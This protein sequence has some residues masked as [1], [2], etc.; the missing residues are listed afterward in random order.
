MP[1]LA[2]VLRELK[3]E[4][5]LLYLDQVKMAFGDKPEIYNK[6]LDIMKNFKAQEIDTPGV[7]QQVSRLFCGNNKLILGFNTFLPDGYKIELPLEGGDA[8]MTVTT[9]SGVLA[10][11]V[12]G[13]VFPRHTSELQNRHVGVGG[14]NL[15]VSDAIV[16][17]DAVSGAPLEFDHAITYV[18]TI[19][20]RFAHE[21]EIYK[22]FLE[23]LH[24]YQKEQRSIK[25]VLEQV[26]Q[27]FA[28]H[29]DLLRE[30]T[31]F[32]PD[33]VQEQAKERLSR[34]AR[35]SELRRSRKE[36]ADYGSQYHSGIDRNSGAG[37]SKSA[38][39]GRSR[40]SS[41]SIKGMSR[42][43]IDST[44]SCRHTTPNT[45][46]VP[47]YSRDDSGKQMTCV[48]VDSSDRTFDG[49]GATKFMIEHHFFERIKESFALKAEAIAGV[50]QNGW[51]RFLK[52]IDLYSQGL[53]RRSDVVPLLAKL[54][55]SCGLSIE[56]LD[57]FDKMMHDKCGN[58][59]QRSGNEKA[60]AH[61]CI[62]SKGFGEVGMGGHLGTSTALHD[63]DFSSCKHGTPSYRAL[64]ASMLRQRSGKQMCLI[65]DVWVSQP[66]GSEGPQSFPHIWK[67]KH[68]EE[69][70]LCEDEHYELDMIL[71]ANAAAVTVLGSLMSRV[72]Q[73]QGN[74][75]ATACSMRINMT[76]DVSTLSSSHL[77][78]LL[79]LYGRHGV[80]LIELLY[81]HPQT[82]IP[83]IVKRLK[84]KGSEW[85]TVRGIFVEERKKQLARISSCAMDHRAYNFCQDD[86][87]KM[88]PRYLVQDIFE[89]NHSQMQVSRLR[90]MSGTRRSAMM[91]E[92]AGML[93][94]TTTEN[95][96]QPKMF[97]K[98]G[99][100]CIH[101]R[102]FHLIYNA[103]ERSSM[104]QHNKLSVAKFWQHFFAHFLRLPKDV[105]IV[106]P[107]ESHI[108][109]YAKDV[110]NSAQSNT[111][112]VD[113]S[114]SGLSSPDPLIICTPEIY[115]FFRLYHLL[116]QR[117]EF[118][119]RAC[120]TRI[121]A[122]LSIA[123]RFIGGNLEADH[124]KEGCRILFGS[125]SFVL[126]TIDKLTVLIL[127]QLQHLVNDVLS[128]KI[129][130]L[131]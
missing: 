3:V 90:E 113:E 4:D 20:K 25:D 123:H 94:D 48:P 53:L 33:A 120:P 18:T 91:Q 112:S 84:Q 101:S 106:T 122:L 41:T 71:N 109:T 73:Q 115:T 43:S 86:R 50:A 13:S 15:K 110:H 58:L 103:I 121:E 30:F 66:V 51:S 130:E 21:P 89:L 105:M 70:F 62:L 12:G 88:L 102:L 39:I 72:K 22:A 98:L 6:F 67:N 19:K 10:S 49:R 7:I 8:T 59:V 24:T 81:K 2:K 78:P 52:C 64:P 125:P 5:A 45:T 79:R 82:T 40:R 128:H 42:I 80:E 100:P 47:K 61:K 31:Y 118:A 104:S 76:V 77:R 131:W 16:R 23:I 9:P 38:L 46:P 26:S 32:L 93:D 74:G 99:R 35:E 65:N 97:L 56:F 108:P 36:V 60:G 114:K 14:G 111:Y 11:V 63:I 37:L 126:S 96:V 85:I 75:L 34:A 68:E 69:L 57:S 95:S 127:K 55:S 107:N 124:Y 17:P 27:L 54:F 117:F 44:S 29:S 83:T 116:F 92:V 119:Y 87:V 1:T 129:L 28:D